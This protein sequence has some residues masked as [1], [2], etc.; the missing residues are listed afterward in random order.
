MLAD[1]MTKEMDRGHLQKTLEG[2]T[3]SVTYVSDFVRTPQKTRMLQGRTVAMET[4]LERFIMNESRQ[5]GWH[6]YKDSVI[7]IARTARAL[8]TPEPR[9]RGALP[10]RKSCAL[11]KPDDFDWKVIERTSCTRLCPTSTGS[12]MRP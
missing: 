2:G 9:G 4:T 6:R 1:C 8:R 3:W 10:I 12:W 5:P 7:Q 11:H